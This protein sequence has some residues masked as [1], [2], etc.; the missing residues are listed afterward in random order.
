MRSVIRLKMDTFTR[1]SRDAAWFI[2]PVLTGFTFLMAYIATDAFYGRMSKYGEVT[3]VGMML[4]PVLALLFTILLLWYIARLVWPVSYVVRVSP[5]LVTLFKS[6][7]PD[8]AITLTP[9]KVVRFRIPVERRYQSPNGE[10]PLEYVLLDGTVH[11][12]P[13]TFLAGLDKDAFLESVARNWGSG[14]VPVKMTPFTHRRI[15]WWPPGLHPPD[16]GG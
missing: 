1:S 4:S 15:R 14:Y 13:T 8:N 16:D 6:T 10:V 11:R 2:L 12:I 3:E 7:C 9:D 5:G